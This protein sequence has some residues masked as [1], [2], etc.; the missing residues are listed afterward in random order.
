MAWERS[1]AGAAGSAV[2]VAAVAMAA[3]AAA[4]AA[5]GL[6]PAERL[7]LRRVV[8]RLARLLASPSIRR[9]GKKME[10]E[11]WQMASDDESERGG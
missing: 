6:G 4:A 7:P 11:T 3:A 5:E 10:M 2:G 8:T 9:K 1:R